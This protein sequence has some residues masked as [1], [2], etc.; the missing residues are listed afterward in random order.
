M[1]SRELSESFAAQWLRLDQLYTSKPDRHLFKAFYSGP[2]GKSTLHGPMMTEALLLFETV[3]IENRSIIDLLDSDFT[4]LNP[5]LAELYGLEASFEAACQQ[6][7]HNGWLPAELDTKNSSKYWVRTPLSDRKRGGVMTMAGPLVLTS[8]PQ[9]TSPVKRGAWLLE[10]IFN[11]PPSEPKV[12]F[13]LEETAKVSDVDQTTQSVRQ[14]FEKHR[15]DPNC[16]SCRL[17]IDPPGFSM[18]VFDAIGA[19][20]T[21]DGSQLVDASGTWNGRSFTDPAGFKEA[22]R[23]NE[24]EVVRGFV[25]HLMS[26]AL[27]RRI[28]H[29]DMP[30]VDRII[31]QA[32]ADD[33]RFATI[34]QGIV[35]SY[36][37]QY[38]RNTE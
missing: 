21:H 7:T 20:R 5:Q 32:T 3:L 8:L 18:E 35:E 22:A 11:R 17:R 12:A 28:E 26:Y 16:Y 13:V 33:N 2:Q 10:T 37:F 34:I 38:V 15:S 27:G 36:P 23:V 6:A 14:R 4:W 30:T 25:E 31:E 1:R 29:F 9:R 24:R 19:D